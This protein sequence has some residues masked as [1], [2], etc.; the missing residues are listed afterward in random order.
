MVV[1]P[2]FRLDPDVH[3][4]L[5]IIQKEMEEVSLPKKART[6]AF[7]SSKRMASH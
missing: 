4:A 5:A 3:D 2:S 1:S 6:D 7:V